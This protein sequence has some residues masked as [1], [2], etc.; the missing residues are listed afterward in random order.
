MD[1]INKILNLSNFHVFYKNKQLKQLE[2]PT[3]KNL[4]SEIKKK[5]S[6]PKTEKKIFIVSLSYKPESKN[7]VLTII[8]T[9]YT[10]DTD[11]NIFLNS[12]DS[13]VT[14]TYSNEELENNYFELYHIKKIINALKKNKI[15]YEKQ[16][17]PITDIL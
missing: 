10:L 17:I 4:K 8:C 11:L 5:V 1:K 13:S 9:Q 12:D 2:S 15:D 14:I 7:K 3:L 6:N 16:F